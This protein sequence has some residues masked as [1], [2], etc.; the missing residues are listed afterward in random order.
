MGD[1][2]EMRFFMALL[3]TSS[4]NSSISRNVA[5]ALLNYRAFSQS[6]RPRWGSYPN[7]DLLNFMT[8]A[9]G[10]PSGYKIRSFLS[11]LVEPYNSMRVTIDTHMERFLLGI[12]R[13]GLSPVEYA[14]TEDFFRISAK[15]CGEPI[16]HRFQSAIWGSIASA[17]TFN[18][19][20]LPYGMDVTFSCLPDVHVM[21]KLVQSDGIVHMP[22]DKDK[23]S[24]LRMPNLAKFEVDLDQLHADVELVRA[25]LQHETVKQQAFKIIRQ[26]LLDIGYLN[27]ANRAE[28]SEETSDRSLV[29]LRLFPPVR[30]DHAQLVKSRLRM[31]V[32]FAEKQG[33][34][35]TTEEVRETNELSQTLAD[36][37]N[38]T[39]GAVSNQ[40]D[41]MWFQ[42]DMELFDYWMVQREIG[43]VKYFNHLFDEKD[44]YFHAEKHFHGAGD[45]VL[46]LLSPPGGFYR[47]LGE[48]IR[49]RK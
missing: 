3:A 7:S 31:R 37:E 14:V 47:E 6:C 17:Y 33:R 23:S 8:G 49:N 34:E 22:E 32:K 43:E 4:R 26:K 30:E 41:V 27:S 35:L 12:G 45:S 25:N 20:L 44:V 28:Q 38:S 2:D 46:A 39:L 24:N 5:N 13:R 19:E 1:A 36:I 10:C 9:L 40:S 21:D 11:N 15:E 18:N 42:R 29:R 48:W 16:P